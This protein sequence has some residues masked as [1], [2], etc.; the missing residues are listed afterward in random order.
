[1]GR[2]YSGDHFPEDHIHTQQH[3]T[4]RNKNKTY[5]EEERRTRRNQ[6]TVTPGDS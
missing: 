4:L 6:R 5:D 2:S 1:M 3:V